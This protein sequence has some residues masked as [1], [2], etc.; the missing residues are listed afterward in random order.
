MKK[1]KTYKLY[2]RE[3]EY[4]CKVNYNELVLFFGVPQ[5]LTIEQINDIIAGCGYMIR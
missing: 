2:D 3:N 1:E 4:I 5:G